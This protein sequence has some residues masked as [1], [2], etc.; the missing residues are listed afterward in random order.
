MKKVQNFI[1]A[2]VNHSSISKIIYDSVLMKWII[3]YN[4][5]V[6]ND[7]FDTFEQLSEFVT[8]DQSGKN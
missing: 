7:K 2:R 6:K 1:E 5:D 3:E 8:H 4:Y